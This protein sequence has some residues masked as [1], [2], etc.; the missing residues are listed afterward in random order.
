[1]LI[2]PSHASKFYYLYGISYFVEM[3][4]FV[5]LSQLATKVAWRPPS[6]ALNQFNLPLRGFNKLIRIWTSLDNIGINTEFGV[7]L[8]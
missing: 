1:M 7:N 4:G 6:V 5:N 2:C 3:M 8:L